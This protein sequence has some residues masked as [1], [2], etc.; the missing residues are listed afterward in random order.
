MSAPEGP[1]RTEL[2][3]GYPIRTDRL[4]LRPWAAT[5]FDALFDLY[6]RADVVRYVPWDVLDREAAEAFLERRQTHTAI[7]GESNRI[8]L[9]ATIPPD[10]RAIG[11]FMLMLT[12]QESRQGE[13]GWGIH[14]DVQG[15]GY[16]TEGAREM[17]RLGFDEL[18]LHRIFA[19]IDPRNAASRR[20]MEH[21]GMQPEGQL[22]ESEFKNGEWVD[23]LIC[24]ILEHEWRQGG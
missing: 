4:L 3:P 8:F 1:G 10:D 22:R 21:L 12:D 23:S 24:A 9:T 18:G 14:P 5:D 13:I 16:G 6:S 20:V 7:D 2:R 19:E 11:D 15:R 17:L